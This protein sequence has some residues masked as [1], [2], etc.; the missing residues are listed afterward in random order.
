MAANPTPQPQG[1]APG[2]AAPAPGGAPPAGGAQG[3]QP[4]GTN[5][6]QIIAAITRLAQMLAQTASATSPDAE[7]IIKN[8]QNAAR[9]LM[10]QQQE[11]KGPS[12]F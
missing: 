6:L 8:V 7:E 1:G 9:K 5:P 3:A 12:P 11:N 2:G 10:P 4:A